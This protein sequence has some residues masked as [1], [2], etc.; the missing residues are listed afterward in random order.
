MSVAYASS[1]IDALFERR[2]ATALHTVISLRA[3]HSRL[4]DECALF[5]RV[6]EWL[7]SDWQYYDTIKDED[8]AEVCRLL[9][10]FGMTDVL[11]KFQEGRVASPESTGLDRW[12]IGHQSEV[13]EQLFQHAR[14][15]SDFLKKNES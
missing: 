5:I 10:K 7:G 3:R 2:D 9:T 11:A 4:P 8:Y 12:F 1:Y 13:E 6:L 15:A 14:H